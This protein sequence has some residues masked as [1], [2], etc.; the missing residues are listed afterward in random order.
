MQAAIEKGVKEVEVRRKEQEN[1]V[2]PDEAE[3]DDFYRT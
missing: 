1:F 2:R 3:K